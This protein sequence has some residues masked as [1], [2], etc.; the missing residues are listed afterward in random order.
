MKRIDQTVLQWKRYFI[1]PTRDRATEID[2]NTFVEKHP[3]LKELLGEMENN[4]QFI[5]AIKL[6]NSLS[7]DDDHMANDPVLAKILDRIQETAEIQPVNKMK[8][9]RYGLAG[10]A[11]CAALVIGILWVQPSQPVKQPDMMELAT[12]ILPGKNGVRLS[13]SDGWNVELRSDEGGII[14]GDQLRYSDGSPLFDDG[15]QVNDAV[16]TLSVPRG[17]DFYVVLADGTKVWMNAESELCYPQTFAGENR[18][19]QLTGEAYFEVAKDKSKPFIVE[20][21]NQRIEVLG[22][23]FNVNA[24]PAERRSAVTLVEG[25][26]AVSIEGQKERVLYP[27]QQALVTHKHLEV[28][29]VNVD[30]YIAWKNDEFMFNEESLVEAA[31]RIGRWYDLDIDVDPALKDIH[32]WGSVPRRE[33]FGQ[34]LKLVQLTNKNVKVE[35]EGRRVRFMK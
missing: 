20:T 32:L 2:I 21:V 26:I 17:N 14:T 1:N 11:A 22:T 24:Y 12:N 28:G 13:I 8:W 34:V 4:D 7:Q 23:H 31:N 5:E 16:M 3:S 6:Y 25:R 30:E 35:I 9:F 27:G 19:V 29:D 18:V 33:N 15:T 10:I